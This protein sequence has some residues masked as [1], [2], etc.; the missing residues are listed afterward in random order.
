MIRIKHL[1]L[2]L[3]LLG[4]AIVPARADF[5]F[6]ISGTDAV[7][8]SVLN[9]ETGQAGSM[10]VWMS[11]NP[12]QTLTGVSFNVLSDQPGLLT[13]DGHVVENGPPQRWSSIQIGGFNTAG[14]LLN[15]HRAFYLPGLTSGVGISTTGLTDFVL[16]SELRF[17]A[18]L[19]PG[20]ANLTFTPTTAGVSQLGGGG[21]IWNSIVKGTGQVNVSAAIPEPGALG[22]LALAGLLYSLRRNRCA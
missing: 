22:A 6:S 14:N 21:N 17:D 5:I 4:P 2:S 7:A 13:A 9:L 8:G 19:N 20:V 10:F 15:N 1:F 18:G 16:H 11:T 12:G 3:L